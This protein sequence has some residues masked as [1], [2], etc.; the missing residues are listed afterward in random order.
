MNT[1][2]LKLIG[3]GSFTKCYLLNETTVLLQ[4]DDPI[5][6]A[7]AYGWFPEHDLFPAVKD[8]TLDGFY[9]ME[10]YPRVS[11]LKNNLDNDQYDIYKTLRG[12]STTHSLNKY[13]SYSKWYEAFES[14]DNED[15]R[16]CMI[17]ALA[18]C[19][20]YGSDVS[21]EISPRNV[22]VKN[23]KLILLDCFYMISKLQE[24]RK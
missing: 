7:M 1:S 21:F 12:L 16:D 24:T 11:S 15:L 6:E 20:N 8:S 19:T 4:S 2:K 13:D 9:E 5:K 23:G 18:A 14:L 3:K 10:Y 22:A 17:S